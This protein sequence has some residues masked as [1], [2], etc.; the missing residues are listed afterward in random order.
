MGAKHSRWN[1]STHTRTASTILL[2]WNK[3]VDPAY[4]RVSYCSYIKLF[5]QVSVLHLPVEP[6]IHRCVSAIISCTLVV[7]VLHKAIHG[8]VVTRST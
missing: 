8:G 3:P 6:Q 2:A 1:V 7:D 4:T 5:S